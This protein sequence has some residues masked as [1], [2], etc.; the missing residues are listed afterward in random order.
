[1]RNLYAPANKIPPVEIKEPTISKIEISQIHLEKLKRILQSDNIAPSIKE[2]RK[3]RIID[4][5][6]SCGDIPDFIITRY[7]EGLHKIERYCAK[8]CMDQSTIE[9]Q[10]ER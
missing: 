2:L 7:Y 1:M 8:C 10:K 5:C 9:K 6:T 3:R 4:T